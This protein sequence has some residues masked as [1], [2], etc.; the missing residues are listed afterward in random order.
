MLCPKCKHRWQVFGPRPKVSDQRF[1]V[2]YNK[3]DGVVSAA[4]RTLGMHIA[5]AQVQAG[6]LGLKAKGYAGQRRY[7]QVSAAKVLKAW[8]DGRGAARG[9]A[10]MGMPFTV[11]YD[12]LRNIKEFRENPTRFVGQNQRKRMVNEIVKALA[13]A[14]G[15]Y[16]EAA[17]MLGVS[18]ERMRQLV[19]RDVVGGLSSPDAK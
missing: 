19:E 14:N 11:F 15:N 4:A 13:K 16:A 9:A 5:A 10:L 7:P 1:I 2:A 17:L 3:N 8:M 6:R 18:R 12:R